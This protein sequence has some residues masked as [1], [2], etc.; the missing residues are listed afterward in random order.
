MSGCQSMC[1]AAAV[2]RS[3]ASAQSGAGGQRADDAL[4]A[5]QHDL[6]RAHA[7]EQRDLRVPLLDRQQRR[8]TPATSAPSLDHDLLLGQRQAD[9]RRAR[10][11]APSRS[12]PTSRSSAS[13]LV[14]RCRRRSPPARRR[15]R[16]AR[17]CGPGPARR[18]S[19]MPSPRVVE[20]DRPQQRRPHLVGQQARRALGQ[21]RRVQRDPV[22]GRVQRLPAAVR[23]DVD[24]AVRLDER[25]HVG[26]R[27]VHAEAVAAALDVQR[28]VEVLRARPGRW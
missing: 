28:L 4:L 13:D 22:L 18:R 19:R 24:R 21:H 8:G 25:R 17:G 27:V 1:S 9:R 20:V 26:D 10:A 7:G 12:W 5:V 6:G 3:L 15:S 16:A 11:R 14:A 2:R 23:L